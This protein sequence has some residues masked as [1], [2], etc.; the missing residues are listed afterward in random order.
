MPA[1]ITVVSGC[2]AVWIAS[3][4]TGW[5]VWSGS[6]HG[7]LDH[8]LARNASLIAS[9]QWWRALSYGTL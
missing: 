3:L 1:T 4:A 9:G 2:V 6:V 8:D 7:T 5:S